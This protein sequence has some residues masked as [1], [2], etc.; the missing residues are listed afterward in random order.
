MADPS[1]TTQV[2]RAPADPEAQELLSAVRELSAQVG[3]LQAEVHALRSQ[4]PALPASEDRPGWEESAHVQRDGAQWVRSLDAPT[5]RRVSIPWLLLEIV[6]LVAVAILAAVAGLDAP[7]IAGVMVAAWLLVALV[8]WLGARSARDRHAL[9][10]G[11]YEPATAVAPEDP[12]WLSPPS[13]RTALD[14][15]TATDGES[16]GPVTRL[17]PPSE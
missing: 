10:Y 6:F 8:E 14:V 11:R 1:E 16:E 4:G 5:S 12:S 17:P 2:S 15:S 9:A 13:E 7:V 3:G